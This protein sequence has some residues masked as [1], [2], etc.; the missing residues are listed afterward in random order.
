MLQASLKVR[1]FCPIINNCYRRVN[2][3]FMDSGLMNLIPDFVGFTL[4]MRGFSF[5]MTGY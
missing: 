5:G 3:G 4:L 2:E 1:G